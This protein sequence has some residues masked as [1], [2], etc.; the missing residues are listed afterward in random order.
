MDKA[1]AKEMEQL[2]QWLADS[3]ENQKELFEMELAFHLGKNSSIASPQKVE[4]AENRLFAQIDKYEEHTI[5]N[6]RLHFFRY[7][8]AMIVAVLLIG[9]GLFAYLRQSTE[10]ITVA[11]LNEVKKVVLPDSSTVWLN[12]GATISYAESFEGNERKVN[13]KGEALF[14]VTKN[15]AKPFIVSSEASLQR[16]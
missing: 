2:A 16:C 13:L 7:A 6:N 1:T 11:A 8:A 12:K 3:E 4:E 9:G 14:H 15:A 5:K 10:T